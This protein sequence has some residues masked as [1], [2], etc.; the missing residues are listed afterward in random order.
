MR[1]SVKEKELGREKKK[2]SRHTVT[3]KEKLIKYHGHIY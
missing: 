2:K 3:E 1:D